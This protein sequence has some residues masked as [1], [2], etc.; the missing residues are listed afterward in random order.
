MKDSVLVSPLVRIRSVG[1]GP[2]RLASRHVGVSP[3]S[4]QNPS[5]LPQDAIQIVFVYRAINDSYV[6]MNFFSKKG[7]FIQSNGDKLYRGELTP[8][9]DEKLMIN[10]LGPNPYAVTVRDF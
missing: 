1:N 2:M 10:E 4:T 5:P 9:A 8:A 7:V 6:Y 3:P